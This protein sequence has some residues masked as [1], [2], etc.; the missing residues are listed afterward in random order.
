MMGVKDWVLSQLVSKSVVSSSQLSA[1]DRFSNDESLNEEFSNQVAAD[2]SHSPISNQENQNDD[3]LQ[4]VVVENSCQSHSGT[5]EK[6][7]DPL[8]KIERLQINFLRLVQRLRQSQDNLVVSKVLYR[9]H[10]ASLIRAGESDLKRTN[11]RSNRARKIAA[12]QEASGLP[13]LDFSFRVLVLGKTGVGKSA[14]INSIFNQFKAVTNAFQPATDRIQEIGGTVN[15]IKIS[16]I[17]T[18]GLLPYS[19]SSVGR[20]RKILSSVKRF[21][22]KSPPDVVL[23]FERLDLMNVGYSVFPLMKLITEVFGSG[24]WFNTILV[25]THS[26]SALPDGPNGYPLSYESYV[27]QCTDLMQHHIHQAV[28][29]SKLE[30]PVLFVENHPHCKTDIT[31]EKILPNGQ[32]WKSQFLLL[33]VC[34]KVLGD[35]NTILQLRD[36]IELGPSNTTRLPSLPHLLSSFLRHRTV[37][38][39]SGADAEADVILSSDME[40]EDEYD[41]L[42]PIRILTKTEFEKLTKLQQKD[43]LD[44][45]DY[46]ETLYMKKQLK[47]E[48]H[49]RG[50]EKMRKDG[51]L[52]S[53]GSSD[54]QEPPEAVQLPDMAVPPSFDSDCPVH[55]Y[56]CLLTGE[57]WLARPVLD[58]HGW[59]HDVGFDGINLEIVTELKHNVVAS[60]TGQL[61]KD[62]QDF[63][64]QSEC[65]AVYV[66]P[67]GPTYTVGLDIQSATKN[68]IYTVHSNAK[69][70]HFKHNVTECGVCVTSFGEKNYIGAKI[71]DSVSV[72]KRLKFSMNA[73]CMGIFQQAAYGGSLEATL[74]GRDYPV[75]NES[76]SMTLTILSFNK[77]TVVGGSF[78]TDFRLSRGTGMSV[79]GN[80]NSRKMGQV[81]VKTS[82]S[83]HVEIALIAVIS[84]FRALLRRRATNHMETLETG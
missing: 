84:I 82:S 37:V 30:N 11:L 83:D 17:D 65:T 56:R 33:C 81:C 73:G 78:Q 68:M 80:L 9:M 19:T 40:G 14:T 53:D 35:V 46:R 10:L 55:R 6:K 16:F 51:T 67:R 27:T 24:I 48:A 60:V 5:D 70:R 54:N 28:S 31:G 52:G 47:E 50:E 76:L 79:S 61:S 77:E 71:E 38:G 2:T 49:R 63:S 57:Q 64:I 29:D 32:V 12:E 66:D 43:Y 23:Y 59:D 44:E 39:P 4:Q 15:G 42:P 36:G 72:G 13:E 41:Q 25:M 3:P 45:L 8:A 20:N 7:L 18:P 34:T 1:G 22:R 58:P 21:I 26:F 69:V 74:R 62:K 75:R